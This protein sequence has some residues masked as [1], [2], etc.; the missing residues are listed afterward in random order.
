M[1]RSWTILL[2][3]T[4]SLFLVTGVQAAVKMLGPTC[5][6]VRRIALAGCMPPRDSCSKRATH[7]TP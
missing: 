1:R 4:L 3:L 6:A 2:G 7:K 5:S